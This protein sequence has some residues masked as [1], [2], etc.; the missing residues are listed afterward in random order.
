MEGGP[1]VLR[2]AG[3]RRSR[4]LG[5]R[6]PCVD[7]DAHERPAAPAG[8]GGW[9]HRTDGLCE[10]AELLKPTGAP[11]GAGHAAPQSPPWPLVGVPKTEGLPL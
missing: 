5:P 1:H 2:D 10:A 3:P 7:R 9:G 11:R 8:P 4:E 6:C